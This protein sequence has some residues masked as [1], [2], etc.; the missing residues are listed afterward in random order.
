[1]D[2]RTKRS[3]QIN[4]LNTSK[5][6]VF[7]GHKH[8]KIIHVL[9]SQNWGSPRVGSLGTWTGRLGWTTDAVVGDNVYIAISIDVT[10]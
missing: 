6:S 8:K 2:E 10:T 7:N 5:S 1:M 9:D 4:C 3:I